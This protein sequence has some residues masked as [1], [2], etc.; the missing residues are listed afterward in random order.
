VLELML[1]AEERIPDAGFA[2]GPAAPSA[3]DCDGPADGGFRADAPLVLTYLYYWYDASSLDDPA[4]ALRPPAGS[5]FDWRDLA[6]HRRQLEDMEQAGVDV[7]LAVYWGDRPAWS[8]EGL[9]TLVAARQSLLAA[10][11]QAPAIGLFLD[12]NLYVGLL[13]D[14]PEL[15]DL[16]SASGLDVLTEQIAGFFAHVPVCHQARMDGRPLV[17]LWRPDTED[18]HRLRFDAETLDL[19]YARLT[20]RLGTRPYLVRERTWDAQ[21]AQAG[22]SLQSEAV[23]G[24]GAALDGP[25][26]ERRTVAV[27][28][29]Y[30]DRLVPWRSGYVR[31]RVGGRAYARDLRAAVVSGTPW[32]LLETWNELWEA[33]AIAETAEHGRGYLELTRRYA[34]LFRRLGGERARDGW[35]DLGNGEG[36]HLARLAS[37]PEERGTPASEYGRAGARPLAEADGASYFHFALLPRLSAGGPLPITVLVEYFDQGGGSFRLE[38]ETDDPAAPSAGAF[39]P[40]PDV[41]VEGTGR[42]RWH[43]FFLPDAD[44]RR[45]QYDGYGDFRLRDMPGDGE[46]SHLFGRVI[47]QTR[48]GV[49]P[50][51][52]GPD[53][54]ATLAPGPD[55]RVEFHWR[56]V[57]G[58]ASYRLHV[59]PPGSAGSTWHLRGCIAPDELADDPACE[60]AAPGSVA[61]QVFRLGGP[62]F[63]GPGLYRWRVWGLDAWGV[64]VGE[65]SDWGAF[66]IAE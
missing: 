27:G 19:L 36:N 30:D 41:T 17:F 10:G 56:G 23:F 9:K 42:W 62:N 52:L 20:E 35:F 65:P 31:E 38:Y 57:E 64:A 4:L 29:G 60:R 5:P 34:D 2:P 37:A 49:R 6:W 7:A 43:A 21:A 59:S 54:L 14:D 51:L 25:R 50:V 22:I 39:Q 11:R 1:P 8:V 48:P 26:F 15:A 63:A 45:R 61:E 12:S 55:R 24:W 58:A 33:T 32:L 28:P 40:T 3:R 53:A 18:G 16:T 66:L 46:P 44:F 13:A 47:V